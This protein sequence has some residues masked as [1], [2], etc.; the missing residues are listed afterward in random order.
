MRGIGPMSISN[1]TFKYDISNVILQ[2]L[3][4]WSMLIKKIK[5]Q[6]SELN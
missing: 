5:R 4:S 3:T 1:T 6:F 2:F